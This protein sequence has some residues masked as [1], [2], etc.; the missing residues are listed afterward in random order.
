[1][2]QELVRAFPD[3]IP[4]K[5]DLAQ[6]FA[7]LDKL[8]GDKLLRA[9]GDVIEVVKQGLQ[10]GQEAKRLLQ[11]ARKLCRRSWLS[12]SERL[13]AL[14]SIMVFGTASQSQAW[15]LPPV[16]SSTGARAILKNGYWTGRVANSISRLPVFSSTGAQAI[17]E[18]G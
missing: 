17:L 7:E 6:L 1:M 9:G 10:L 2:L 14:K 5:Y 18:N 11:C 3:R 13:Q 8:C 12:R 15:G 4:S 16:F